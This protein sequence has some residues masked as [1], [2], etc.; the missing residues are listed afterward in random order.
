MLKVQQD[1]KALKDRQEVQDPL[2][3]QDFKAHR[4]LDLLVFK[5]DKALKVLLVDKAF[6]DALALKD[7]RAAQSLKLAL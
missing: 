3:D 7:Q 4:L 5:A 1:L 6:K 2:V